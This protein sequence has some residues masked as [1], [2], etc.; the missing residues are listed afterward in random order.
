VGWNDRGK[1]T[2]CPVKSVGEHIH[3]TQ[4]NKPRK[5]RTLQSWG[6]LVG[7]HCWQTRA[8]PGT[9]PTKQKPHP[10]KTGQRGNET[11]MAAEIL[12]T[13]KEQKQGASLKAGEQQQLGP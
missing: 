3:Y 7:G 2:G 8:R 1:L 11:T 5:E 13:Q 10:W 9:K 4:N 12:K 6:Q